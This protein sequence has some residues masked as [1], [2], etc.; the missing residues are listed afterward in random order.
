MEDDIYIS[1]TVLPALP[2]GGP[3]SCTNT[4]GLERARCFCRNVKDYRFYADKLNGCT[5][6]MFCYGPGQAAYATCPPGTLFSDTLQSCDSPDNVRCG[7][8]LGNTG[9]GPNGEQ[10]I[11]NCAEASFG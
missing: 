8:T 7:T 9:V 1:S 10:N 2:A 3:G 4:P 11:K 5:G 6:P